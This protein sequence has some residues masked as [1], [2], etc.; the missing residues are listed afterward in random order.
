MIIIVG[1]SRTSEILW[2]RFS[3]YLT[4]VGHLSS[5]HRAPIFNRTQNIFNLNCKWTFCIF[6][7]F[8]MKWNT[9]QH[10]TGGKRSER[11]S[12]KCSI[13][14]S[15]KSITVQFIDTLAYLTKTIHTKLQLP[16][17]FGVFHSFAIFDSNDFP[18]FLLFAFCIK[19]RTNVCHSSVW[20][21]WSDGHIVSSNRRMTI[22]KYTLGVGG[23]EMKNKWVWWFVHWIWWIHWTVT[24]CRPASYLPNERHS[25]KSLLFGIINENKIQIC[26]INSK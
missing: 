6:V 24:F 15:I 23:K 11:K 18:M 20:T 5:V 10:H 21:Q 8:E 13:E 12:R 7:T 9:D 4:T 17:I 2:T 19:F 26:S 16:F 3:A 14:F 22:Y 1:F 25:N